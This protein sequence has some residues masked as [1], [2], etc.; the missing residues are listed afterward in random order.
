M[1]IGRWGQDKPGVPASGGDRA[2]ADVV[3]LSLARSL[4]TRASSDDRARA[5]GL[6]RFGDRAASSMGRVPAPDRPRPMGPAFTISFRTGSLGP[7]TIPNCRPASCVA[8][9]V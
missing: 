2:R 3:D 7:R 4:A 5:L 6:A 1:G 9:T 8:R